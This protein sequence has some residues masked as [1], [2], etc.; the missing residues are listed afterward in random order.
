MTR[1]GDPRIVKLLRKHKLEQHCDLVE[2]AT[3]PAVRV[4]TRN[5]PHKPCPVGASKLGGEPDLHWSEPWPG[6]DDLPLAFVGQLRLSEI[7]RHAPKGALPRT[8]WLR[9]WYDELGAEKRLQRRSISEDDSRR[10]QC[11]LTYEPDESRPLERRRWPSLGPG[12]SSH[13]EAFWA[14]YRET[15]VDF[16]S[17]ECVRSADLKR[18]MDAAE[19]EEPDGGWERCIKF[20]G[21]VEK[22]DFLRGDHRILGDTYELQ[23]DPRFTAACLAAGVA[24][25]GRRTKQKTAALQREAGRYRL[26]C[27]LASD[28]TGPGFQ[29]G[30]GGSLQWWIRDDHLKAGYLERAVGVAEQGG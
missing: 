8:G 25:F 17:F 15:P 28:A 29:W 26:L 23:S 22:H 4:Q 19:Q 14:P 1:K 18:L 10:Q 30:D 7:A 20:A 24:E 12:F 11:F 16:L 3:L 6:H 27:R 9:F 13:T 5:P 2:G 21:S